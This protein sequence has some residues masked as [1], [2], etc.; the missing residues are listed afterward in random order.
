MER[1]KN[2][3]GR[4]MVDGCHSGVDHTYRRTASLFYWKSMTE[5]VVNYVKKCDVCQKNKYDSASYPRL[6]QLLPIPSAT[7]ISI[8]MDSVSVAKVSGKNRHL[9]GWTN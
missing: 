8:S 7:W 3:I 4:M 9:G 6:L 2:F 1:R 5:K